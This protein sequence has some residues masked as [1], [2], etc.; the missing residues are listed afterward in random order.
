MKSMPLF[1][2]K[3]YSSLIRRWVVPNNWMIFL[4]T[5]WTK[6]F[7][8]D[9]ETQKVFSANYIQHYLI[10]DRDTKSSI[11]IINIIQRNNGWSGTTPTLLRE[12]IIS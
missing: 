8:L 7:N 6:H 4:F 2:K 1:S 3:T 9:R 11:V 5:L 12:S 10:T